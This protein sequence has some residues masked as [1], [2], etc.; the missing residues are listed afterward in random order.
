MVCVR[1]EKG[2]HPE[3]GMHPG[4]G[5]H[6]EKGVHPGKG[7]H[8]VASSVKPPVTYCQGPALNQRNGERTLK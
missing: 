2:V 3:K 1:P 6:P 7:V 8:P 4:K 5:V